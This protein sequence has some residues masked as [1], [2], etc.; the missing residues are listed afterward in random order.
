MVTDPVIGARLINTNSVPSLRWLHLTFAGVDGFFRHLD[1]PVGEHV[2]VTRTTGF[3]PGIAQ[4]CFAHILSREHAL[5][6]RMQEQQRAHSWIPLES[7]RLLRDTTIGVLGGGDIGSAI[8]RVAKQGFDMRVLAMNRSGGAVEHADAVF[9]TSEL[10][11]ILSQADFVVSVLPSTPQ[12]RGLLSGDAL[13]SCKP[14]SL[15]INVGRGDVTSEAAILAAIDNP[16]AGPD[17]AVLDVFTAEPLDP[18]EPLWDHPKVTISPHC[19]GLS[20]PSV[21]ATAFAANLPR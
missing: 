1:T 17:A 21:V 20:L 2:T 15:F 19:A 18:A 5:F 10:H 9:R 11:S 3:G 16:A 14:G 6:P 12:T 7:H 4:F 8:C 13:L